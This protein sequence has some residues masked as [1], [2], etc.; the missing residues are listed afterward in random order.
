MEEHYIELNSDLLMFIRDISN[1]SM[2]LFS[3]VHDALDKKT[4][5][6]RVKKDAHELQTVLDEVNKGLL[7]LIANPE[8]RDAGALTHLVTYSQRL[9]DKLVNFSITKSNPLKKSLTS[10]DQDIIAKEPIQTKKTTPPQ[11]DGVS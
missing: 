11:T 6:S 10:R 8:R 3:S 7:S 4:K 9:K 5:Y 1:R 2:S